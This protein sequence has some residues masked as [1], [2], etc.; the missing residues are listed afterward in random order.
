M[1]E[2]EADIVMW[3][4]D[5]WKRRRHC[6]VIAAFCKSFWK[7]HL[8]FGPKTKEIAKKLVLSNNKKNTFV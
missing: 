5:G 7:Q 4:Q 2:K 8:V 6:N 1:D 3:L